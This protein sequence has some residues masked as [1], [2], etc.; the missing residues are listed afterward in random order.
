MFTFLPDA[1]INE[2][3]CSSA[4]AG[5][6]SSVHVSDTGSRSSHYS[7]PRPSSSGA[8]SLKLPSSADRGPPLLTPSVG[9]RPKPPS[10]YEH[11][12]DTTF[13]RV[14]NDD[15]DSVSDTSGS[16]S[17]SHT[18]HA[19]LPPTNSR[20]RKQPE[21]SEPVNGVGGN[22]TKYVIIDHHAFPVAR[23]RSAWTCKR[24]AFNSEQVVI[25]VAAAMVTR[26]LTTLRSYFHCFASLV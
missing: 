26:L 24:R 1:D 5:P 21:N 12:S 18:S 6:A 8:V 25:L 14:E 13:N 3:P 15:D 23:S 11:Q 17:S 2:V 20:I 9:Q 16:S 10:P 19:H 4:A 7:T 22:A